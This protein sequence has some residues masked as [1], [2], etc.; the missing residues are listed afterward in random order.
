MRD[1]NHAGQHPAQAVQ[2]A[3]SSSPKRH[4]KTDNSSSMVVHNPAPDASPVR[5]PSEL[6]TFTVRS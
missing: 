2:A 4:E 1:I 6:R 5:S 3:N